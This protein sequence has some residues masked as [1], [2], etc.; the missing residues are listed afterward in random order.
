MK[1]GRDYYY[2]YQVDH[3]TRYDFSARYEKVANGMDGK[4]VTANV[5]T[6]P[7]T[8]MHHGSHHFSDGESTASS[9]ESVSSL[10]NSNSNFCVS[11]SQPLVEWPEVGVQGE[12][13][14]FRDTM[15]PKFIIKRKSIIIG[16]TTTK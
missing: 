10:M 16:T 13:S 8:S 11:D 1:S 3:V 6:I 12:W 4:K 5:M 14:M 7:T 2:Y 9:Y 15:K